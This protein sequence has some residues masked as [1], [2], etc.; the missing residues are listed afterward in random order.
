MAKF[1][2][3]VGVSDTAEFPQNVLNYFMKKPFKTVGL[4]LG[5]L[6]LFIFLVKAW[7]RSYVTIPAG[8]AG[9]VMHFGKVQ[10]GVLGEGL[11]FIL[12]WRDSVKTMSVQVLRSD[13]KMTAGS[14]DMQDVHSEIVLNWSVKKE[15]INTLYQTV[16]DE[17]GFLQKII[18][19]AVFES[20]KAATAKR[21]ADD[22]LKN[23][24][25]LRAEFDTELKEKLKG[26]QI[27][28]VATAITD[29]NFSPEY[30][31]AIEEKQV[32]EQKSQKAIYVAQ[33]ADNMAKAKINEARGEAEAKRLVSQTVTPKIIDLELIK[34]WDG[35]LP[36]YVLG[37]GSTPLLNMSNIKKTVLGHSGDDN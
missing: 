35:A 18:A 29:I 20:F 11:H 34:K 15:F 4:V 16:G 24:E 26:Y 37:G 27:V 25:A 12:P 28:V 31:K 17:E 7:N 3:A 30:K 9:V 19:P 32:A 33:E 14:G 1:S 22:I 23:R 10:N 36:Q 2:E 13:L 8:N 6:F 5:S 21:H